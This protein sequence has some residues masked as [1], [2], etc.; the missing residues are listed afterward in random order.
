MMEDFLD[1]SWQIGARVFKK[2]FAIILL[3]SPGGLPKRVLSCNQDP[4][5]MR[6]CYNFCN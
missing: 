2:P 5:T 4:E 1:Y 6:F 3:T